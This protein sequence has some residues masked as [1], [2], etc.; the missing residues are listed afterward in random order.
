MTKR[1]KD[2]TKLAGS[3][4][5][6]TKNS[7][8]PERQPDG[9]LSREKA[10]ERIAQCLSK[11]SLRFDWLLCRAG[12]EPFPVEITMAV[13]YEQGKTFLHS[14]WRDLS[15]LTRTQPK[16]ERPADKNK[17]EEKP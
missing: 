2:M 11:G 14:V 3:H 1:K 7:L 16:R 12:G 15:G 17:E 8:S 13:Y 4:R 10:G 5:G 6:E 9:R